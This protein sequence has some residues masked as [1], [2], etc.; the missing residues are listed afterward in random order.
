MGVFVQKLACLAGVGD[1]QGI[2]M[3]LFCLTKAKVSLDLKTGF[4]SV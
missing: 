2:I 1:I 3:V 4:H